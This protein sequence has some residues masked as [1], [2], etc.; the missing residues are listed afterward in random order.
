VTLTITTATESQ[1]KTLVMHAGRH[2]HARISAAQPGHH[3]KVRLRRAEFRVT[4][5][6][7]RAN[8]TLARRTIIYP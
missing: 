2:V 1:K 4:A 3:R 6:R 7:E 5:D 8:V